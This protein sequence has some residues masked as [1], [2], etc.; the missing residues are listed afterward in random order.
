MSTTNDRPSVG[1]YVLATIVHALIIVGL[2][3]M[4]FYDENKYGILA[5]LASIVGVVCLY[6]YGHIFRIVYAFAVVV[7][8]TAMM[9]FSVIVGLPRTVVKSFEKLRSSTVRS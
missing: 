2:Y 1:F 5:L 4:I 7:G 6:A 8:M 3:I 9:L